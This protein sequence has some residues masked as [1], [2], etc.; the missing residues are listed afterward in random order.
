M[1]KEWDDIKE[2][3]RATKEPLSPEAWT[4]MESKLPPSRGK[5]RILLWSATIL[6]LLLA[7]YF[8]YPSTEEHLPSPHQEEKNMNAIKKPVE[9]QDKSKKDKLELEERPVSQSREPENKVLRDKIEENSQRDGK[10]NVATKDIIQAGVEELQTKESARP[11]QTKTIGERAFHDVVIALR[12]KKAGLELKQLPV[13]FMLRSP[14]STQISRPDLTPTNKSKWEM[15]F[16]MAATY[17]IPGLQY[18]GSANTVHKAYGEAVENSIK[19]GWGFDAGLE[20]KYNLPLGLKIGGGIGFREISL[21]SDYNYTIKDIPVIDGASG[22][23]I[24]YIPLDSASEREV[25]Q[26]GSD[27]YTFV[28]IPLSIYYEYPLSERWILSAEGIHNFT[29]LLNQSAKSVDP[30]TLELNNSSDNFFNSSINSLQLRLG[31]MYRLRKNIYIALEPSYREYYQ[32]FLREDVVSWRPKDFSISLST[33]IKFEL[34]QK[35][36]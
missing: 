6:L 24:A 7:L 2:K 9:L 29:F 31:L 28:N 19:N 12:V 11:E 36:K 5:K 13:Q 8:F 21:R 15:R 17:N 20:I 16:F 26:T 27:I 33:I 1:S 3:I 34:P 4:A 18:D 22:A 23:I 25:S 30:T 35:N 10:E 32:D 14:L